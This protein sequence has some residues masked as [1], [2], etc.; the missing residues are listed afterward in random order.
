M[1]GV[2]TSGC[3]RAGPS[4]SYLYRSVCP[5]RLCPR[6]YG[7]NPGTATTLA[8]TPRHTKTWPLHGLEGDSPR[9]PAPASQLVQRIA[10]ADRPDDRRTPKLPT[11]P[12]FLPS[13]LPSSLPVPIAASLHACMHGH[14]DFDPASL[15]SFL[16]PSPARR[17]HHANTRTKSS[18]SHKITTPQHHHA[19]L[20]LCSYHHK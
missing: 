5:T 17:C 8:A 12:P 3:V 7:N 16:L 14:F 6:D 18:T 1:S 13:I 20:V 19:I 4:T 10:L 2:S 9:K 15:P 11:L